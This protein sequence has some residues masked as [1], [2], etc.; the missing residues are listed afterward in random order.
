MP[1]ECMRTDQ[2]QRAD[3]HARPHGA[4]LLRGL[5]SGAM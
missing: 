3:A 4:T 5:P 1:A 2:P